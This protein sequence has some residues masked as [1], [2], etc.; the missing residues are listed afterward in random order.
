MRLAVLFFSSLG[1]RTSSLRNTSPLVPVSYP[2]RAL[3]FVGRRNGGGA[4][5]EQHLGRDRRTG[6]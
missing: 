1:T 6:D 2:E 3:W 4:I 5:G